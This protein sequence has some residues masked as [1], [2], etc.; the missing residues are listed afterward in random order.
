[1][2]SSNQTASGFVFKNS[3]LDTC[4]FAA[5]EIAILDPT[6]STTGCTLNNVVVENITITNSGKGWSG[7][8][9]GLE[10]RGIKIMTAGDGTS[11]GI[12]IKNV[13]ISNSAGEG[14]FLVGEVG[15]VNITRSKIT[16]SNGYGILV[17][18]GSATSIK[19]SLS[20]SLIYNNTGSAGIGLNAPHGAGID[21]FHN[22]FYNNGIVNIS[23]F[24]QD[25]SVNIKNNIF[26]TD[27]GISHIYSNGVLTNPSINYNCYNDSSNIFNYNSHIYSTVANFN[28][29][30]AFEANGIGTGVVALKDVSSQD[31]T[32]LGTSSC[33]T[34]GVTGTG[35][36][37]DYAGNTF[38]SS[39]PS[40][41]AFQY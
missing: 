38:S 34:L 32:L 35:I 21:L 29:N 6:G 23:I 2:Y 15:N 13:S 10:G 7:R 26:F 1:M 37:I 8:R 9:Y 16:T 3:T 40:A 22:T 5:V 31:F 17:A 19:L 20:S 33:K 25:D 4:G 41:G 18:D 11:T 39:N 30:E 12:S 14:I 28:T 27:S 36:T 24:G